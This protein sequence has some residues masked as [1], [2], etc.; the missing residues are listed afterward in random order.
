VRAPVIL[1]VVI[2]HQ[3]PEEVKSHL[4]DLEAVLP[5][6]RMAVCYGG[7][8]T[9]FDALDVPAETLFIDDPTLRRPL[10]QSYT[11]LLRTVFERLVAPDPACSCVHLIEWDHVILSPRY[12]TELLDVISAERVGLVARHCADH[13]FVNWCHSIDVLDDRELEQL[14]KTI[15]VRDQDVPSI[16]GGLGNGMTIGRSALEQ[17]CL[18]AG[19]MSRYFELYLPTVVY[20]LGYRVLDAPPSTSLFDHLRY[21]PDYGMDEAVRLAGEGALALHPVKDPAVRRAL[22]SD[23]PAKPS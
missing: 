20:H 23:V 8:R 17:L 18:R 15:S 10:A 19:H 6:R 11:Q 2:T 4:E 9:D 13:T 12:E 22:L 1:Y 5:G 21:G 3:P 7:T 16:W 14:L